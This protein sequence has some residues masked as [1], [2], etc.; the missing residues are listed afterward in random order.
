MIF[1]VVGDA[2]SYL[3][4]P[5][6]EITEHIGRNHMDMCRFT[7]PDDS[8]YKKVAA[9]LQR[10]TEH[11][12]QQP[13][14][15]NSSK[16]TEDPKMKQRQDLLNS[17]NFE[18][19]DFRRITIKKAHTDTC[20]WLLECPIYLNWNDLNKLPEH[21]G[22]LW[23][24]GKAGAGKSTIMKFALDNAQAEAKDDI[25]IS[26]FFNAQGDAL[27]KS[28]AGMY[29]SLLL[30][31]LRSFPRLQCVFDSLRLM[32]SN[33]R[34]YRWSIEP[35]KDLFE[36]VVLKL[37]STSVTCFIDA[38]DECE[39][40]QVREMVSFFQH[41][42]ELVVLAKIN[43]RVCL[44]S[45][46][47]PHITFNKGYDLE[48][49]SENGHK[50]DIVRYLDNKLE[51]GQS[52]L[53]KIIRDEIQVKASGVFMWVV[54]V[55][56]ILNKD[57]DDG[58]LHALQA[59]LKEIPYGLHELFHQLLTR[60]NRNREELLLCI[61]W[62]LFARRMLSP[63][64]LY[65]AV[66]SGSAPKSLE[67]LDPEEVTLSIIDRFIL[68]SSKGLIEITRPAFKAVTVQ[69]IHESVRDYF[70]KDD[71]LQRVWPDLKADIEA[72]SHEL[73]KQCCLNYIQSGIASR[74]EF[75]NWPPDLSRIYKP[76]PKSMAYPFFEYSVS[77]ILHHAEAAQVG[78]IDQLK[79]IQKFQVKQWVLLYRKL[80]M[81][82]LFDFRCPSLLYLLAVYD[83]PALVRRHPSGRFCFRQEDEFYGMPIFAALCRRN[84]SVLEEL[85]R[86][87]TE[88]QPS[89]S[90]LY[91]LYEQSRAADFF[92]NKNAV[93]AS[94]PLS[95]WKT[96][97][98]LSYQLIFE[99][100][101]SSKPCDTDLRLID[102][103]K[104]ALTMAVKWAYPPMVELL[105]DK[106]SN[107][108]ERDSHGRNPLSWAVE[109]GE[110]AMT[111]LLLHYGA[112]VDTK[113]SQYG[114][115]LIQ[116]L[117]N[118]AEEA[119]ASINKL[120]PQGGA[121][122]KAGD[123]RGWTLLHGAA[124]YGNLKATLLFLD[125]G[126]R[127]QPK[128]IFGKTPLM[129]AACN[130]RFGVSRLLIERGADLNTRDNEGKTAYEYAAL[131]NHENIM[132]LLEDAGANT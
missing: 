28:T 96:I 125:R 103:G 21:C 128:D 5:A 114:Q 48:L 34:E 62:V 126:A 85:L 65:F 1:Q 27:E 72:D 102:D 117:S 106:D 127:I 52:K 130:G 101:S 41:L 53:A 9:A 112:D 29:R 122:T 86:L 93:Y 26:F 116:T 24:R 45:R 8:Q 77:N 57:F 54:L 91:K 37:E 47:Y 97:S 87:Q 79:F 14:G 69:F 89:N 82:R 4:I 20:L 100:Y 11:I 94:H 55:V 42:G 33:N 92:I 3:N 25:I 90:S 124:Y 98:R 64:D 118:T 59:R 60:D 23:L 44:S 13:K 12:S 36:Q 7:G 61:R 129:L 78:G 2:S 40:G 58:R 32:G 16:V 99:F 74:I 68:S 120:L 46:Y 113:W 30:Q 73:L 63:E 19:I 110:H 108:E 49:E 35:L 50:Q 119:H 88:N 10:L 115:S 76:R 104:T 123:C 109:Q 131:Y 22:F 121:D 111:E 67:L 66:L 17:L 43:F 81:R 83:M 18:Q 51:I 38:L 84:T 39:E 95:Y 80:P 132:E 31:L 70:L 105:L 15:E 75:N 107:I 56:E 6:I 71:G